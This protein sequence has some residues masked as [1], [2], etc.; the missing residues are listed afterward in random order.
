MF[1]YV[2]AVL[3]F[4]LLYNPVTQLFSPAP[5]QIRR[6]PRPQ[7]NEALLALEDLSNQ[8]LRCPA[9]SYSAHILSKAPLV[10]YIENFLS[11]EERSHLLDIR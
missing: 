5:P 10:V 1:Q 7:V 8:T 3:A 2:V 11:P 9:D 6:T 4:V